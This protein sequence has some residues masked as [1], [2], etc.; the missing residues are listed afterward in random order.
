MGENAIEERRRGNEAACIGEQE[1]LEDCECSGRPT[2]RPQAA[3]NIQ[4]N[5]A[6]TV[7]LG[8]RRRQAAFK[9]KTDQQADALAPH[10]E[11]RGQR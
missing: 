3:I 10:T 8:A 4:H 11:E 9:A 1:E 6:Q 5:Q 7:P 2:A